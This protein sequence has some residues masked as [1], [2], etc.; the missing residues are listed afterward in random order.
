MGT[1]QI[2]PSHRIHEFQFDFGEKFFDA[3]FKRMK[4]EKVR[5]V[6][7]VKTVDYIGDGYALEL[8]NL[9]TDPLEAKSRTDRL[10]AFQ[11]EEYLAGNIIMDWVNLSA[12]PTPEKRKEIAAKLWQLHL[13]TS[14]R[15]TMIK[16]SIQISSTRLLRPSFAFR[17][18]ILVVNECLPAMDTVGLA[19]LMATYLKEAPLAA[20][21]IA[22]GFCPKLEIVDGTLA[23]RFCCAGRSKPAAED[24]ALQDKIMESISVEIASRTGLKSRPKLGPNGRDSSPATHRV[25]LAAADMTLRFDKTR[26]DFAPG[27]AGIISRAWEKAKTA[28]GA[29]IGSPTRHCHYV[30]RFLIKRW[31]YPNGK[32]R[33]WDVLK[34]VPSLTTDPAKVAVRDDLYTL[35][36]PSGATDRRLLEKFFQCIEDAAAR[37][38]PKPFLFPVTDGQQQTVRF[39]PD[40]RQVF[41]LFSAAQVLRLPSVLDGLAKE[42]RKDWREEWGLDESDLPHR[43]N[44]LFRLLEGEKPFDEHGGL[45]AETAEIF[46]QKR[47]ACFYNPDGRRFQT[48]DIPVLIALRNGQSASSNAKDWTIQFPLGPDRMLALDE[49]RP[50]GSALPEGLYPIDPSRPLP[51]WHPPGLQERIL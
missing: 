40:F 16:A 36:Q 41:A 45:L 35:I 8:K 10:L 2:P 6:P 21:D 32:L 14:L 28:A 5:K 23:H 49:L 47:W 43:G 20:A 39:T 19:E 25:K 30:P 33:V 38:L 44:L 27:F 11:T 34:D 50:N 37:I 9:R 7:N 26:P 48:G 24:C 22:L 42:W 31:A 17:G 1:N 29:Q 51:L 13:G 3:V 46:H 18:A 4:W 12:A 15:D